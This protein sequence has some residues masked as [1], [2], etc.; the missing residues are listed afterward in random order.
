MKLTITI[1]QIVLII[2]NAILATINYNEGNYFY[3]LINVGLSSF[4]S[5]WLLCAA[6]IFY[7][8]K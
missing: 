7:G 1:I 6:I 2:A 3:S 4:L 5:G 8:N